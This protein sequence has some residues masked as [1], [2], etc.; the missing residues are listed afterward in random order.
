MKTLVEKSPIEQYGFDARLQQKA[1]KYQNVKL[2][3]SLFEYMFLFVASFLTLNFGI[4]TGLRSSVL[5]YTSDPWLATALYFLVGFLCLW[6]VSLPFDYYK[7]YVI[8]HK[9]GLS[10]QTLSSWLSDQAKG[11]ILGIVILMI[12]VQGV[13]YSLRTF[14]IYWWIVVW[15]FFSLGMLAIS[16]IEPV[17]IMPLF[18]KY[19]P[20]KE[21]QL[22]ERLTK[23]AK[24]AGIKV[25]GVFEMKAG[26]KTKK[27]VGALAGVGNPRRIILSD[28]LL[29]NYTHDEI[30]GVIGH[31]LGH[32]VFHHIGK[33]IVMFSVMMLI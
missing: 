30:E 17:V 7:E 1:K 32:H 2:L 19:P 4:S 27:A 28:T 16:Y 6:L 18:F 21:A 26:V 3:T 13:Y 5:G 11:L 23:L 12:I 24:K 25:V 33:M 8:E 29:A 22:I 20:L 9:F 10:T 15:I 31:E 14:P